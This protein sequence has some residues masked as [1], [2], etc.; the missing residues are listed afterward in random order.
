MNCERGIYEVDSQF[1]QVDI[2]THHTPPNGGK[3]RHVHTL[4]CTVHC[5]HTARQQ[6]TNEIACECQMWK[7]VQEELGCLKKH[8]I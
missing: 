3:M 5:K 6:C 4:P 7:E 1:R 8:K 2:G